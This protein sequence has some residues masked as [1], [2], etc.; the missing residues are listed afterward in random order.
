[1][2]RKGRGTDLIDIWIVFT[3]GMT[4]LVRDSNKVTVNSDILEHNQ[5]NAIN[6]STIVYK[7]SPKQK[8]LGFPSSQFPETPASH[9]LYGHFSHTLLSTQPL[10]IAQNLAKMVHINGQLWRPAGY[11]TSRRQI[12]P[13]GRGGNGRDIAAGGQE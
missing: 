1:M 10:N 6:L 4:E 3:N 12:V 11:H 2:L 7:P 8:C 5:K 13:S 9:L